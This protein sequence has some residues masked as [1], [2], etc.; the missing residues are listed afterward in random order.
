MTRV[1]FIKKDNNYTGLRVVGHTGYAESGS[2]I[3]CASIS[4]IVQAGAM[5]ILEVL[6]IKADIVRDDEK[7]LFEIHLPDNLS[8]ELYMKSNIIF[9]TMYLSIKDI[10]SGYKKFI[11][12]EEV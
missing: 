8:D 6:G 7:G 9:D 3:L 11:K 10:A 4:S 1:K 5:G 12:L 2:D